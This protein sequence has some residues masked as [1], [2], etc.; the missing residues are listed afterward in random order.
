MERPTELH[1][2][3]PLTREEMAGAHGLELF[4]RMIAGELPR[5]P[6]SKTLNFWL[7]EADE[8]RAV[9]VGEP[10]PEHFNPL[11]TI[12][13]GWAATLLDSALACAV[14]TMLKPGQIYTSVEM[15]VNF[16]RPILPGMGL[17]RCEGK[18]IQVGGRIG[19][20]EAR[21]VDANGKLLAHGTETC[22]IMDINGGR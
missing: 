20:S 22:L 9:F 17:V 4:R 14:H 11:G 1:P 19:T 15:K 2:P 16:D 18:V 8:G 3:R 10:L 6:I 5:P 7:A 12:H 21:L 13:G